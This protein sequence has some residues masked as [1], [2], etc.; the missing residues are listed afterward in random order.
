MDKHVNA[1]EKRDM[2]LEIYARFR[3]AFAPIY[4]RLLRLDSSI[5][6]AWYKHHYES[7]MPVPSNAELRS[8]SSGPA[9]D[10]HSVRVAAQR[11]KNPG[12]SAQEDP[13]S[14]HQSSVDE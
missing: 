3:E 8:R 5:V 7:A 6:R 4:D 14:R 11:E 12:Q 13:I 9:D 2:D 10:E 1:G